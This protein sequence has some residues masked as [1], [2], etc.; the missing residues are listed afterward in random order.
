MQT[1]IDDVFKEFI[2]VGE[3][4]REIK[5][6]NDTITFS[7][8]G[9]SDT[10]KYNKEDLNHGLGTSKKGSIIIEGNVYAGM[11]GVGNAYEINLDY[12]TMKYVSNGKV[13]LVKQFAEEK[14]GIKRFFPSIRS[15]NEEME[16][17]SW[18]RDITHEEGTFQCDYA[19]LFP[20][21][22]IEEEEMVPI[23]WKKEIRTKEVP[24]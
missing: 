10:S 9:I 15:V 11:Y 1:T 20:Y 3:G 7:A 2:A 19:V 6:N 12:E 22:K 4:Y 24:C 21:K 14:L 8:L 16:D 13:E 5:W 23:R 18:K 17:D